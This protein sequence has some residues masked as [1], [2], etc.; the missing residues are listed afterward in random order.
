M[1]IMIEHPLRGKYRK[2]KKIGQGAEAVVYKIEDILD[3]Q[4]K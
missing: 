2:L 4:F 3:G 1:N